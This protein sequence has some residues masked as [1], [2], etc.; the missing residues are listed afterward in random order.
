MTTLETLTSQYKELNSIENLI[1]EKTEADLATVVRMY[2]E[3]LALVPSDKMEFVRPITTGTIESTREWFSTASFSK[4]WSALELE[5]NV[6]E[7]VGGNIV[8]LLNGTLG[9]NDQEE[10]ACG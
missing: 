2:H 1:S 6:Y 7:S 9:Y 4:G 3:A 8:S 5:Y 10:A